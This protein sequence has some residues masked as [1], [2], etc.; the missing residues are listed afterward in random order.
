MVNAIPDNQSAF[1]TFYSIESAMC[2]VVNDMRLL[3]DDGKCDIMILLDLSAAF[4]TVVHSILLHDC[5]NIGIEGDA[6]NYLRI[7]FNSKD[8]KKR[9]PSG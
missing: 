4:D 5:E 3:M 6:L 2:S 7:I 9:S 1:R 8:F